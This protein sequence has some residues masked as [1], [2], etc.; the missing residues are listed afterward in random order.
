MTTDYVDSMVP[1][2]LRLHNTRAPNVREQH[3]NDADAFV[4]FCMIFSVQVH[5]IR[6]FPLLVSLG[7]ATAA[8]GLL[9]WLMFASTVPYEER[10]V[11]YCRR[12]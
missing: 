8:G 3:L 5:S 2:R 4:R 7:V 12:R 11:I 10:K 9:H 6:F 1:V